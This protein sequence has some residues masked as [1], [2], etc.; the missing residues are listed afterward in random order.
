MDPSAGFAATLELT[1]TSGIRIDRQG[2]LWHDGEPVA[3]EGFRRALYK[4]LDRLPAPD[5]R[6][7]IRLDETRYAFLTVDDTPLVAKTL[8]HES[9][10]TPTGEFIVS[11]SDGTEQR[12]DVSTLT[13]DKEGTLRAWVRD[14]RLEARLNTAA[15]AA[16]APYLQETPQG[17]QL[18]SPG[19]LVHSLNTRQAP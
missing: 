2:L 7:I 1:R 11:L 10:G 16:L 6:Y 15:A 18:S 9:Q 8:R 14:G 4:W 3:H 5:G 12:L 19:G 13:V 17:W